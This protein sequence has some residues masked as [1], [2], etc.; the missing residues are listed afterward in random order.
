MP[1]TTRYSPSSAIKY[2]RQ[3][4]FFMGGGDPNAK[5]RA[6]LDFFAY[7]V[8]VSLIKTGFELVKVI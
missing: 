6:L 3:Q 1:S 5:P 8:Q 4:N 7:L 2:S